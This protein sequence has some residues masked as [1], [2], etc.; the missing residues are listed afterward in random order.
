M[1]ESIYLPS[2]DDH[3]KKWGWGYQKKKL[4]QA[5]RH[6][7]ERGLA[8]D[9]GAHVGIWT[10]NLQEHFNKVVAFEPQADNYRCLKKNV[11]VLAYN[12]ALGSERQS[13]S[14]TNPLEGNSGGWEIAEGNTVEMRLLDDFNY[15]PDLIKID[16][17]GYELEVL[18][19]AVETLKHTKALIIEVIN[20]EYNADVE[21][22]MNDHGFVI[23]QKIRKDHVYVRKHDN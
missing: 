1:S 22:F 18:K 20:R 8:L 3:F 7:D 2:Y 5:L 13:V 6:F 10:H 15:K 17:Q 12:I 9:I 11:D 14:L 4:D 16:V 21:P 19:G 23:A